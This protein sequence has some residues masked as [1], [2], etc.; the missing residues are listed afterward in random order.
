MDVAFQKVTLTFNI[1]PHFILLYVSGSKAV[2]ILEAYEGTLEDDYPPENERCEHGEM[3]L[4]KV[5]ICWEYLSHASGD[6]VLANFS[7]I[8]EQ[9]EVCLISAIHI[10]VLFCCSIPPRICTLRLKI[11]SKINVLLFITAQ[12]ELESHENSFLGWCFP[13]P[14]CQHAEG[15][16]FN[17]HIWFNFGS[18]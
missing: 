13:A 7:F 6:F 12:N 15:F 5:T 2:D 17:Q 14:Y 1:N 11:S 4:Y 10:P 3:L 16:S 8:W 9:W 18:L